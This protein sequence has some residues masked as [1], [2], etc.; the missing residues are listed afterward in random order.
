MQLSR[1]S[2]HSWTAAGAKWFGYPTYWTNRAGAPS[3]ELSATPDGIG[4]SLADLL[5]FIEA[6]G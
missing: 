6:E 4:A 1:R 3:E 5:R 2:F